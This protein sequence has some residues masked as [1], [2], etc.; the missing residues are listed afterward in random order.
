LRESYF[1]G[2]DLVIA[3]HSVGSLIEEYK[4]GDFI[5]LDQVIDRTQKRDLSYY[6]NKSTSWP[7]VYHASFGDPYDTKLRQVSFQSFLNVVYLFD[8]AVQIALC[9]AI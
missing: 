4:P 1:S 5:L 8:D 9:S 2:C 6:D 7:G 3:T